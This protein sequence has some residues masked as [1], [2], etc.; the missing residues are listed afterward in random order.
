MHC[1]PGGGVDV[2]NVAPLEAEISQTSTNSLGG[3]AKLGECEILE[4]AKLEIRPFLLLF[5]LLATYHLGDLLFLDVDVDNVPVANSVLVSVRA[6]DVHED[7]VDGVHAVHGVGSELPVGD[8][9]VPAD[10][11]LALGGFGTDLY[12]TR[13][14]VDH[15]E[16]GVGMVVREGEGGGH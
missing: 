15:G 9:E 3:V 2:E 14:K 6:V 5:D 10:P 7:V 1:I 16:R 11:S 13:T 12:R 8:E 4:L